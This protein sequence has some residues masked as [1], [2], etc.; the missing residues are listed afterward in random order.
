MVTGPGMKLTVLM[1]L[2]ILAL[3]ECKFSHGGWSWNEADSLDVRNV[4]LSRGQKGLWLQLVRCAPYT[5]MSQDLD[6]G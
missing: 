3:T 1:P 2:H 6:D 5:S 4:P